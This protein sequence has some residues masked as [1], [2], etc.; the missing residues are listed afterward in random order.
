M[1]IVR[2]ILRSRNDVD[3]SLKDDKGR[4]APDMAREYRDNLLALSSENVHGRIRVLG[5]ILLMFDD[6]GKTRWNL[7]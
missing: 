6:Y 3:L 7:I 5:D 1:Q 4:T 2:E